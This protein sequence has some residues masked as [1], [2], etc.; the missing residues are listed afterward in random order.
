MEH[1]LK[2]K[3]VNGVGYGLLVRGGKVVGE[4]I[5]VTVEKKVPLEM[6]DEKDIIP[7]FVGNLETDVIE[8]GELKLLS[9]DRTKKHRPFPMGVS[10][11]H[12]DIT[13][14]TAGFIAT[15]N[16][17]GK[18]V[19][20]S[21]NHVLANVNQGGFGDE[22]LQPGP[23]DGGVLESDVV[24]KLLRFVEI[25]S[26]DCKISKAVKVVLN[27]ILKILGSR[28]RFMYYV[29]NPID[30]PANKVD[31]AAAEL[32][33]SR[34]ADPVLAELVSITGVDS[35]K[36]GDIVKKSGR[37]TGVTEGV[38]HA[39]DYQ[40]NVAMDKTGTKIAR[41][42]DQLLIKTDSGKF[43]APGD[44][45][46]AIVKGDK[47]VGLLFAGSD[48]VTIANKIENVFMELKVSV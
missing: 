30:L 23:Y 21:N 34:I 26:L 18:K 17:T 29:D 5:V 3:N 44:S 32:V 25:K 33:D 8:V 10:C 13:A 31:C 47:L 48:T 14:G 6:L 40:A 7:R 22:I 43:S 39:V 15:D 38:I 19:L 9:I 28:F 12:K 24:A 45:G 27:F 41:F 35:V 46:S 36:V 2:K 1:L 16:E 42:V 37:T 4:G 11:G 20:V